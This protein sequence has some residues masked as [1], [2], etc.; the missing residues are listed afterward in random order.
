LNSIFARFNGRLSNH[1]VLGGIWYLTP[2]STIFQIYRGGQFLFWWRKPE[3]PAA[4]KME[5]NYL[6]IKLSISD[7]L[8]KTQ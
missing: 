6:D 7:P 5:F 8:N 1:Q 2:L 4:T 3:N